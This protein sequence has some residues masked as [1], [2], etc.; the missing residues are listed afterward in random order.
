[1][2]LLDGL[3]GVLAQYASGTASPQDA[4][5]HFSQV[6]QSADAGTLAS[7]IAAMLRSDQTPPFSQLIGQLFA[8]GSLEQKAGMLSTL[9]SSATPEQRARLSA[10]I[11]GL[12][13]GTTQVSSAQAGGVPPDA[14]S[15]LAHTIEQQSPAIVDKM[16]GFYAQH[17]TLVKTLG[18]AAM[19]IAMR[20]IAEHHR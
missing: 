5:A 1:M 13:S 16:S 7:G 14:V 6:A 3:K 2:T 12:G 15:S 18:T 10:L 8:S 20:R 19:M 11:P 4:D 17:P 9:L